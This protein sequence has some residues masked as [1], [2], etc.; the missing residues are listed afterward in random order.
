VRGP[1]ES[2][3]EPAPAVH[4]TASAAHGVWPESPDVPGADTQK[5]GRAALAVLGVVVA[6]LTG[7]V[8]GSALVDCWKDENYSHGVL[9]PVLVAI[10]AHRRLRDTTPMLAGSRRRWNVVAWAALVC[11]VCGLVVGIAAAE[12]F[13]QRT[14]S[15]LVIAGASGIAFG[16]RRFRQLLPALALGVCMIPLPYIL[17]YALT[18]PLQLLSTQWAAGGVALLGFEVTRDGNVFT[19][20]GHA[21]EVVR[22]CSG[23][24]SIMAL[25]TVAAAGAVWTRLALG[26]GALLVVAAVPAAV[27]G[28]LLRLMITALLVARCGPH[29]AEGT[30][31]EIVGIAC[32]GVSLVILGGVWALI[33]RRSGGGDM[34][35]AVPLLGS[36][37]TRFGNALRG[38]R[39]ASVR[40]AWTA[41]AV[42]VLVGTYGF[43]LQQHR[44]TPREDVQ[45]ESLPLAL[46]DLNA[47]EIGIDERVL[48]QVAPS[49]YVFRSYASPAGV[50][51][52]LYAGYY[53]NP[54]QGTQIHSPLHCYPGAGWK[55]LAKTPLTV[56]DLQGEPTTMQRLVVQ[57]RGRRDVVVYWYETRAGRTTNDYA[58]K[59]AQLRTSLLR[60]PQ[61]AA[62]V[63]WSTSQQEGESLEDATRRLL[64]VVGRSLPAIEST[65]PFRD[66]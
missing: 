45:L 31:H 22:A 2:L 37:R 6:A 55:I 8:L 29:L 12:F 41:V 60:Q 64:G 21:L 51:F 59:F 23:I 32:F 48:E 16:A 20:N 50:D 40:H 53:R 65:L 1:A 9:V 27:V 25:A 17:Y 26:R 46:G 33:R 3:V 13:A 14:S 4:S 52:A 39:P 35:P 56:R 42:L 5:K 15:I 10:L 7:P 49:S 63:R 19:V 24:R 38:A 58:L 44:V 34:V 66:V 57:K 47:V 18:F 62:F 30:V 43:F 28:N 36:W 61:D 11:G 54:G